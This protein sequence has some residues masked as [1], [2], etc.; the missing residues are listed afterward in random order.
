MCNVCVFRHNAGEDVR[1]TLSVIVDEDTSR[2]VNSH[3]EPHK[4]ETDMRMQAVINPD[5]KVDVPALEDE[6]VEED[7]E[8]AEKGG[9]SD[10]EVVRPEEPDNREKAKNQDK[11]RKSTTEMT[12]EAC[13]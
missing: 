9:S 1:L 2:F 4:Q 5:A 10:E 3:V 7:S 6:V 13:I 12:R 11:K 8:D